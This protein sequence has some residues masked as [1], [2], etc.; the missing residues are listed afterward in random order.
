M[1]QRFSSLDVK[2]IAHELSNA[3][4]SLRL[5]NVYDLSSRIF[6]LKFAKPDHR[7]QLVIDSG[8]RCHLTEFARDTAAAPSVFVS[9]LRKYLRTRRV[10]AVSQVG[11]DRI[12]EFEFSDGQYRLFLEFYA[13]GNIILTDKDLKVLAIFRVVPE[14]PDQEELR[15]GLTYS[16]SDRQNYNGV[17]P[18]TIDRVRNGL[19][20]YVDR[21]SVTSAPTKK[22]AKAKVGD[23]LRR[24][25]AVSITEYPPILVE[26]AL[27]TSD[28]DI[29]VLPQTVLDDGTMLEKLI[30]AL[31]VAHNVIQQITSADIAIGYIIAKPAKSSVTADDGLNKLSPA[32][33]SGKRSGGILYED[34]HPF[35]PIQFKNDPDV[36]ILTFDGFNKTVDEFFSSIESQKLESK[37]QDREDQAR[38]K[39][40]AAHKDHEKRLDALQQT[41]DLNVQKAQ[42]IE[43]NIE[44]IEEATNAVNSLIAQGMDWAEIARLIEMEQ[45]RQNPV[46]QTI[47]LPLKLYENTVTLLLGEA[48]LVE[49]YDG[50][51]TDSDVSQSDEESAAKPKRREQR[52]AIDIDL[53]S[54]AWTNAGQYYSQKRSAATKQQKT[55]Q[56]SSKALK[57]TEK[58]INEDLKKG[59]K[60][61]K[62][63]LRPVRAQHWFEK[64]YYF[65]SSDGH[66]VLAGKDAQQTDVLYRRHLKRG[67]VFVHA[68]LHGATPVIIKNSPTSPDAPIPPSTLS[69][70]G[71][72][73]V[74]T[75]L[76]WESKAVMSAWWVNSDQVSKLDSTG[77]YISTGGFDIRGDKHFLPP[78]QLILGFAVIFQITEESK[79]R[80]VKYRFRDEKEISD[81]KPLA[82]R[83]QSGSDRD[84]DSNDD[85][86]DEDFPDTKLDSGPD[87]SDEDEESVDSDSTDHLDQATSSTDKAISPADLQISSSIRSEPKSDIIDTTR[88]LSIN[89]DPP[90]H[91]SQSVAD[92]A[93][94]AILNPALGTK[95]TPS[96]DETALG[97]LRDSSEH[98]SAD[99]VSTK[100]STVAGSS[101]S[102]P[103]VRGKKVKDRKKAAKYALQDEEDRLRA[104]ERLGSTA[105][106]KAIAEAQAKAAKQES[107]EAQKERRR[108]QHTQAAQEEL[109][110]QRKKQQQQRQRDIEEGA[111]GGTVDKVNDEDISDEADGSSAAVTS[112]DTLIGNPLPGDELL[113]AIPVCA[114]WS[115]LSKYKYKV[116]LQPG[117][118]K[119]GKA[120]REILGR[121]TSSAVRTDAHAQDVERAWPREL[122]LLKAWRD[123][124]VLGVVPVGK[125]RVM[126]GGGGGT[127][128]GGKGDGKGL[129]RGKG[130]SRGGRGSK[131]GK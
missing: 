17:P 83:K 23:S 41:Q 85:D 77:E 25:L 36:K 64:F 86:E 54:S 127:G 33:P 2:I 6:L 11:T 93:L 76:T 70:A 51:S 31:R 37:L 58:R 5:S 69:Q 68:D 116:K 39:L 87:S 60:Q 44:R 75:S 120:V 94:V 3:L 104:M 30:A 126:I 81:N 122:E 12:L 15:V 67:D 1:K 65:I 13:S 109:Q 100:A 108:R 24:A 129:A 28:F 61:E 97:P 45:S 99:D 98:E 82:D 32:A 72:L 26:H 52:I 79:D 114:P 8:F 18:I 74:A 91:T 115:A 84:V 112:L 131:R 46:A 128:G 110:R 96:V 29:S 55:L 95:P 62:Q 14:G 47:K 19:Q 4:C 101:K 78:A 10:T 34:F 117:S 123:V 125:V 90:E 49:D 111:E 102:A 107:L 63:V 38:R 66:L 42:I 119:K 35:L 124:E 71:N 43:A 22:K 105:Q 88:A 20:N 56:S 57:S 130:K 9:R 27:R 50:E 59:L 40:A 53:G 103:R 89:E 80:H 92:S 113:A 16:I 121:W 48:D 21:E 118:T 7:K 106:H 73:S